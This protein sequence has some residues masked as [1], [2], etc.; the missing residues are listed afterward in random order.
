METERTELARKAWRLMFDL[1]TAT[2]PSRSESLARRGLSPNDA[3]ALWS[4][5]PAQGRPIGELARDWGCDPSNATFIVDRLERAGLAERQAAAHDRRVKLV[6]L[7]PE[8]AR[9][10]AEIDAEFHEPPPQ[11]L[12]LDAKDLRALVDALSKAGPVSRG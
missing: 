2:S 8:G 11:I 7:T 4:L 12:D 9:I 10:R 5:D 6:L 1:L 3:R